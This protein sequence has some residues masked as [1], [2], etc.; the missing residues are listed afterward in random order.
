MPWLSSPTQGVD[1][2]SGG[3]IHVWQIIEVVYRAGEF[4]GLETIGII[5]TAGTIG[6]DFS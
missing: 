3:G 4:L 6:T 5:G 1:P 2:R